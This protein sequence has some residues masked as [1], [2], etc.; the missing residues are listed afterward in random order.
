MNDPVPPRL[1]LAEITQRGMKALA[2]ELG[3]TDTA[4]FIS[5]FTNGFGDYTTDR[6][7]LFAGMTVDDITAAMRK[8]SAGPPPA[9]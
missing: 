5:Q 4:R 1:P 2:R 3:P 7:E 8:E 6:D 9:G